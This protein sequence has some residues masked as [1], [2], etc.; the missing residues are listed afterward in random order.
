MNIV[1][2]K[3]KLVMGLVGSRL[4]DVTRSPTI[5]HELIHTNRRHYGALHALYLRPKQARYICDHPEYQLPLCSVG[6]GKAEEYCLVLSHLTEEYR[7]MTLQKY[8]VMLLRTNN[9]KK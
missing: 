2:Y 9:D 7:L 1:V 3:Q 5:A 6:T 8:Q 4:K